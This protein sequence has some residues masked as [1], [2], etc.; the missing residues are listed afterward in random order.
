MTPMTDILGII[1]LFV[2]LSMAL[3]ITMFVWLLVSEM[4]RNHR[5]E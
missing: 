2:L 3:G 5:D 1:M 4:W